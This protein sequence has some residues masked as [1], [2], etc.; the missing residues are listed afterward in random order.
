[1]Y[2][3]YS[4]AISSNLLIFT[5]LDIEV[6]YLQIL[7]FK[8]LINLSATIDFPSLLIEYIS[9]SLSFNHDLTKL[10]SNSLP[11]PAHIFFG[12]PLDFFKIF[13]L[14]FFIFQRNNPSI[15]TKNINDTQQNIFF[16]S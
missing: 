13:S 3:L 5:F 4:F 1:M 16:E 15:F 9:I 7:V 8:V 14:N 6:M 12:F 10:W 2:F 11:L